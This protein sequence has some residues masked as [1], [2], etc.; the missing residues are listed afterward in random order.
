M[1]DQTRKRKFGLPPHGKFGQKLTLTFLLISLLPL[2]GYAALGLRDL[3]QV[4]LRSAE[5]ELDRIV[6]MVTLA[7]EAQEALD[8][9]RQQ[10]TRVIDAATGASPAWQEGDRF[11]TLRELIRNIQIGETGYAYVLDSKGE[12]QVHPTLEKQ[13]LFKLDTV[14]PELREIRDRA[15]GMQLGD[16]KTLRYLWPDAKG[17]LQRKTAKFGYFKPYDWIIVIAT[18]ENEILA[19]YYA[20]LRFLVIFLLFT[21]LAVSVLALVMSRY[22][23]RPISQLTR[24][25]AA[26]ADGDFSVKLPPP[27]DDE[28]GMMA[29]SFSVMVE[30][31]G[32]ARESLLDWSRTLEQKV[33]ERTDA[34][35]K[36]HDSML[37]SEKMASL[38]KLSAM[39]AHELNNPL[40]GVLS[41]IKLTMKLLRREEQPPSQAEKINQ[42]L[43]LS[44][45]EVKRCG[46]IVKNLLMFSKSSF[47]EF[48]LD[49]VSPLIDK[50][51]ALIKHTADMKSVE[52]TKQIAV[53]GDDKIYCDS[54]GLQQMLMALMINALDA[55]PSGGKLTIWADFG[56]ADEIVLKVGDTGKGIHESVLPR[57]FEPFFSVKDSKK[58]IGMGLSVVYGIIQSHAG[59]VEVE[60]EVGAGT[61]FIITLPRRKA[62]EGAGDVE[63]P[64]TFE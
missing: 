63:P 27:S 18:F 37:I 16:V 41:Y 29:K 61:T 50:S 19:P 53:P 31:L 32:E 24:A 30:R 12:F 17:K 15:I 40:S 23:M 38:G 55:M 58:N 33:M 57:I 2:L 36:A 49:S 42:Y 64:G 39:V 22:M 43:D 46:E 7:C 35:E 44:A 26:L 14:V 52:L 4:S 47:G 56:R 45:G 5:N 62:E 60:S 9:M 11:L 48:K 8:R 51:I 1:T 25:T 28:I 20:D 10:T 6:K 21:V 3:R 34:L 59:A 54:S 13:N